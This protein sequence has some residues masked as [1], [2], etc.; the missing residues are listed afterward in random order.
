M[1]PLRSE[2]CLCRR[3]SLQDGDSVSIKYQSIGS[4]CNARSCFMLKSG[5]PLERCE[6]R[7][8]LRTKYIGKGSFLLLLS[9]RVLILA[10]IGFWI[11][12]L[13]MS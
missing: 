11:E 5:E 3:I 2:R 12:Y 4:K 1:I 8:K 9:S 13:L 6:K 10:R 7:T